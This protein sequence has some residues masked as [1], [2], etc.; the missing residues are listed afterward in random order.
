[1]LKD[2]NMRPVSELPQQAGFRFTAH[3]HDGRT[4]AGRM[5]WCAARGVYVPV[6]MNIKGWSKR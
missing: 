3:T 5:V 4:L 1:M 6:P 2:P